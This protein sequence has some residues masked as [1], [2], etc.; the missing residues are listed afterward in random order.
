MFYDDLDEFFQYS[1]LN[2]LRTQKKTRP[3]RKINPALCRLSVYYSYSGTIE[4]S[5]EGDTKIDF[6]IEALDDIKNA[7]KL[8]SKDMIMFDGTLDGS[9]EL[10]TMCMVLCTEYRLLQN[11]TAKIY[12]DG[13]IAM[14]AVAFAN[15]YGF[16]C[17]ELENLSMILGN[18]LPSFDKMKSDI[19]TYFTHERQ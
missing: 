10:L 6:G 15:A 18:A 16:F 5:F 19:E 7:A 8:I 14:A 2:S 11:K 1:L 4:K 3:R 12:R 17:P 13:G 9:V